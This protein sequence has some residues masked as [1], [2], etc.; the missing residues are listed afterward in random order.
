VDGHRQTS[1]RDEGKNKLGFVPI[2]RV[3]GHSRRRAVLH[4]S[5]PT[6]LAS[7]NVGQVAAGES[8]DMKLVN[9]ESVVAAILL[10]VTGVYF[11]E[12]FNIATPDYASIGS[13]VWP[14]VI[15]IPLLVLT[16]IY[17]FQSIRRP[18]PAGEQRSVKEWLAAYQNPISSF[19]IFFIF[20][21]FLDYLGMLIAGVLLVFA[22]LTVLGHRTPKALVVHAAIAIVSVG[23]VWSLF[24]FVLRVYM[25]EGEILRLY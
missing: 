1:R 10:F 3:D 24:T 22:L 25:P 20:L 14:R 11:W 5:G 15:L 13:D 19:I 23:L 2:R 4:E 8:V 21:L 12:T 18:P 17:L 6:G 7:H 9:K 16:T